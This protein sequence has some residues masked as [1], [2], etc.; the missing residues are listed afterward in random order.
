[1]EVLNPFGRVLTSCL[2]VFVLG[3]VFVVVLFLIFSVG[4]LLYIFQKSQY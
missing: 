2:F 3:F 1:M 4:F